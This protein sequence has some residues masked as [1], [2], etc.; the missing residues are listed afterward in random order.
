LNK[1][2]D[3]K[4]PGAVQSFRFKEMTIY[5]V[6]KCI[7]RNTVLLYKGNGLETPS[8]QAIHSLWWPIKHLY[9]WKYCIHV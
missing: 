9:I 4:N 5:N 1:C 6:K 3:S 8:V 2:Q 7:S